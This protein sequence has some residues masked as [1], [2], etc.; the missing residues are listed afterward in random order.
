MKYDFP[1]EISEAIEN[2]LTKKHR[3]A[4]KAAR[5]S[6]SELYLKS[7]TNKIKGTRELTESEELAYLAAR[8]PATYAANIKTL[9]I[10]LPFLNSM[11]IRSL[12]DIGCGPGTASLAAVSRLSGISR[13]H[14][15]E[16]SQYFLN[17]AQMGIK[18]ISASQQI[19]IGQSLGDLFS[20]NFPTSDLV[21]A[22]Y[23]FNEISDANRSTV[24]EKAYGAAQKALLIIEP[25]TTEGF[26]NLIS[27][28][29]Q[30]IRAGASILAP[31][32]HT[33]ECPMI[34][35]KKWCHFRVRFNRTKLHR[36]I[37]STELSYEDEPFAFLLCSKEPQP[38]PQ[39]RLTSFPY[40]EK[41][42]VKIEVCSSDGQ[43]SN[44]RILKRNRP[45][46]SKIKD[47]T[48]GDSF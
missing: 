27:I 43:L 28:R 44:L 42:F 36:E 41:G 12:V 7:S 20:T 21:V 46:F 2:S 45:E 18:M 10:I 16:R 33:K 5:E 17:H 35:L 38:I 3:N 1:R 29:D 47:L 37:K 31:C 6:T 15:I 9:E 11:S 8:M 34:Q 30:L 24:I 25:G 23:V 32:T 4:L 22:S 26:N 19:T 39:H 13:V 40:K 48:W 14:L